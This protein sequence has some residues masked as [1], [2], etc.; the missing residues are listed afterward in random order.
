MEP[1]VDIRE[2]EIFAEGLDHSEGLAFDADQN[3]WAGGELGQVYRIDPTGAV[4]L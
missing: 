3:L 4:A 2:F 1:V